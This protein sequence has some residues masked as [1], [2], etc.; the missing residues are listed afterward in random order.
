MVGGDAPVDLLGVVALALD[1]VGPGLEPGLDRL[2]LGLAVLERV[3][4]VPLRRNPFDRQ[5]PGRLRGEVR[6]LESAP[7]HGIM[8]PA[9]PD[10]PAQLEHQRAVL[11]L[12]VRRRN[13]SLPSRRLE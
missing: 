1:D 3:D 10:P 11:E 6:K 2:D 5:V 9:L 4:P 8:E 13:S 12:P 7:E